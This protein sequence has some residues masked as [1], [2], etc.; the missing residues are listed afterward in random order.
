M[1][2]KRKDSY[3]QEEIDYLREIGDMTGRSNKEITE[4]FNKKFNQNRTVN[5]IIGVKYR[6]NIKSYTKIYTEEQLDYLRE[7]TPGR[8]NEEITIMFNKKFNDNR[9]E[10]SI[11]SVRQENGI[12]TGKTGRF[13]KGNLPSNTMEVGTTTI[14]ADGY[15]KTK[16]AEP[17]TWESTHRLIW[18]K[19]NGSIP[20]G[21]AILFGDGDKSNLDISNLILVSRSQLLTLNRYG[22]IQD[23]ADLTRIGI[24]IADLQA[25]IS[26]VKGKSKKQK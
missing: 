18:E 24:V 26:E 6:N 25:K 1:K 23:N 7:I 17:N 3:S 11:K 15:H 13:E 20:D 21:H 10:D 16:I 5:S 12:N 14:D 8:T 9:T 2:R 22:L 19:H 4:M